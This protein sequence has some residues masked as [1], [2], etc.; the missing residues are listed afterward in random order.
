LVRSLQLQLLTWLASL[1]VIG[2]IARPTLD[3]G[4]FAVA[5]ALGTALL[6]IREH[7]KAKDEAPRRESLFGNATGLQSRRDLR[8]F[9]DA[10]GAALAWAA[11]GA[12]HHWN[13]TTLVP[14][15]IDVAA[16]TLAAL[17]P[18][19]ALLFAALS[20]LRARRARMRREADL[21]G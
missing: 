17:V 12:R 16:L 19:T 1:A 10:I 21:D 13:A 2:M 5:F 15:R 8:I 11:V 4:L 7:M 14:A 20:A 6:R 3:H 18:S 9:G